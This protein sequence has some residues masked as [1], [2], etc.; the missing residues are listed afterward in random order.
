MQISGFSSGLGA[1]LT[2]SIDNAKINE[3]ATASAQE[4]GDVTLA[5]TN[6]SGTGTSDAE[7][8]TKDGEGS[9]IGKGAA[10]DAQSS[11]EMVQKVL[12]ERIKELE[13]QLTEEQKQLEKISGQSF[14]SEE[15]KTS[16]LMGIQSQ[17]A[18]TSAA[19]QQAVARLVKELTKEPISVRA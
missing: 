10:E 1:G 13:K 4:G 19:L 3:S 15:Q 17:I 5:S 18:S 9:P 16:A 12:Q 8:G 11:A 7:A 2:A 6:I 14:A